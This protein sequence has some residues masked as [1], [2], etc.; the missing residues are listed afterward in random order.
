MADRGYAEAQ[1]EV[2]ELYRAVGKYFVCFS[3]LVWTMR[4]AIGAHMEAENQPPFLVDAL[5]SDMQAMNICRA[6]FGACFKLASLDEEERRITKRLN[7]IIKDTIEERN[8][9]AH[10]D[11]LLLRDWKPGS[12]LSPKL[13][14]FHLTEADSRPELRPTSV[15]WLD[16]RSDALERLNA[17]TH[18][19]ADICLPASETARMYAGRRV[20]DFFKLDG[21]RLIRIG[22]ENGWVELPPK[23][24]A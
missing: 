2:K 3:E 19:F 10:G 21:K 16:E 7:R 13:A 8:E 11:W 22:H 4:R 14:R 20:R 1:A 15:Q 24:R 17:I 9:L 23:D 6:F 5:L 18:E 12:G